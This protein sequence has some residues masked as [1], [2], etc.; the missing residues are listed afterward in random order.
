VTNFEQR[1][2]TF[3]DDE[4]VAVQDRATDTIYV[5]LTR[6][7]DNLGIERK[8]Q[9]QRIR[10][11]PV[12]KQGLVDV[13][14]DTGGGRQTAQC[15]RIDLI[16]LWLAGVNANRVGDHVREKLIRYQAEVASVLWQAFKHDIMSPAELAAQ[17]RPRSGA[18]LALDIATAIQHLAQ[19]Q[20]D[21]E[22]SLEGVHGRMDS[23]ARFLRDFAGSTDRRLSALELHLNPSEQITEAQAGELALAVKAVGQALSGPDRKKNGYQLVYSELYRRYRLSSYKN[24]PQGK[25][26]EV[27]TWLHQWHTEL[28]GDE[29]THG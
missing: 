10:E 2:V 3:Y 14:L 11:H 1:N 12:L 15:L 20:L 6:L 21:I 19:Q 18:E 8:R 28:T 25:F 16:P 17:E 29:A 26:D 9:A 23:M 7:C 5:P 27:M 24:L 13:P 22:R 4:L